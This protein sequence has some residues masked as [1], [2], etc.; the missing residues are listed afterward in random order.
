MHTRQVGA[1]GITL[2]TLQAALDV[3]AKHEFLRIKLG[4]GCG[5][6]RKETAAQLAALLDAAVVGQVGFT[7]TL[8]RQKGLPRPLYDDAPRQQQEQHGDAL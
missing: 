8:Y 1:K 6:A 7:I 2:N 5:L 4:E 3:L